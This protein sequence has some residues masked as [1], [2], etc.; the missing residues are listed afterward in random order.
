MNMR[1]RVMI[2]LLGI[3]FSNYSVALE[4]NGTWWLSNAQS[5][6]IAFAQGFI[7]GVLAGFSVSST[8]CFMVDG[9]IAESPEATRCS[10]D[11]FNEYSVGYNRYYSN[12]NPLG[13]SNI[14]TGFYQDKA[15]LNIPVG[16]AIRYLLMVSN[17]EPHSQ[18]VLDNLRLHSDPEYLDYI[19]KI[20]IK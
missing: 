13:L 8:Y 18:K 11:D 6:Q 19:R 10:R 14:L 1:L 17:N 2:L 12:V 15:N 4:R 20:F 3:S 9:K 7:D 16:D 5:S